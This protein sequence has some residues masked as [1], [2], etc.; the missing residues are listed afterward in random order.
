ML[1]SNYPGMKRI[2][3]AILVMG[4]IAFFTSCGKSPASMNKQIAGL[5]QEIKAV[6]PADT[7]KVNELIAVYEQYA[8]E[9]PKDTL[10][11]EYLFRAGGMCLS[12][13]KPSRSLEIFRRVCRNYPQYKRAGECLF[14]QAFVFEN[15][16]GDYDNAGKIY[17]EFITKYPGHPLADDAELSLK[18]LGKP[19]EAIL[20]DMELQA[21]D[22]TSGAIK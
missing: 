3:A 14:M 4:S 7:A 9:F 12:F 20:R 10:S 21:A 13:N 22:S 15:A 17:R 8:S 1:T 16:L 11:P 5:E 18:Y 6:S 19:A 2:L